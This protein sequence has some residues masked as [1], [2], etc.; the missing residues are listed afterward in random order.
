MMLGTKVPNYDIY[1]LFR[2]T[3]FHN[4]APY[5]DIAELKLHF[6]YTPFRSVLNACHWHAAPH[7]GAGH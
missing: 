5:S 4:P 2:V 3:R 6:F 1:G 7:I